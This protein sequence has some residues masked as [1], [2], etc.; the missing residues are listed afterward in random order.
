M[1]EVKHPYSSSSRLD[2]FHTVGAEVTTAPQLLQ[3]KVSYSGAR[4]SDLDACIATLQTGQDFN[5]GRGN[6]G[7]GAL[8]SAV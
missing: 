1:V 7:R 8:M 2:W 5:D 6:D 3:V 4:S